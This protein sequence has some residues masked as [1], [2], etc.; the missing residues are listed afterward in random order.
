MNKPDRI[1]IVGGGIGGLTAALALLQRGIDVD[2]YEQAPALAE[3]GAG[4]QISANGTRVLMALGLERD[5]LD[6]GFMPAGKEIRLWSTGTTWTPFDLGATSVERYGAP[7]VTLHRADL[8]ALLARA[9]RRLKGDAITLGARCVDIQQSSAGVALGFANGTTARAQ[10]AIGADGVHSQVRQSLFGAGDATFTGCVAWR[11][12]VP[13]DRLPLGLVRP[14][15]TNWIGPGR[16]FVHYP[17][18]RGEFLNFVGIVERHDWRI[19]SWSAQ[20]TSDECLQDFTGWHHDIQAIIASVATPYKWALMGREPMAQWSLGRVTLLGDACHP[21]LPFLA[22]GAVM[23]IEDAYV[24]MR[25]LEM[26]GD[27]TLAFERYEAARK[28]RTSA[29]VK[30]SATNTQ[31]FHNE[32][33]SDA[34]TAQ[35]YIDTEWSEERVRER[36]E[37]LFIYDATTVRI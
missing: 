37:W 20:G 22:Q 25:A 35:E 29:I 26:F 10:G 21:T 30:G 28:Q 19:E 5:L 1:A 18:R 33:L 17:L 24:L 27:C 13:V 16:H 23:A 2:V 6:V 34:S 15:G 31:R 9:V 32:R 12:V 11:G 14:V 36:Y 4:V 7:Y 3:T 8:H